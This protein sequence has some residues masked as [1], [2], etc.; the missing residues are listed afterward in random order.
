MLNR[1]KFSLQLLL[2]FSFMTGGF[3]TTKTADE[4]RV[5]FDG[6]STDAWRGYN[7]A[8]FPGDVWKVE[9]GVLRALPNLRG[10]DLITKD[11]YE[12]F[13]LTLEWKISPGGNSGIIYRIAESSAPSYTSGPEMQI[14]D[15]SANRDKPA[16]TLSGALYDLI[17]PQQK[18]LM[19]VGEFN[20]V[21]LLVRGNHVEH[22]LNGAKV[23]E[24]EL[25]SKHLQDLIAGS[26]FKDMPNF[27]RVA[28]GYIALQYHN[29]E[30]SFRN[31]KIRELP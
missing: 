19:P 31:I 3:M 16:K 2:A 6:K 25:G 13:E 7:Q 18:V 8:G 15:D 4:W 24:Y 5:L 10:G 11:Q 23:V 12:N 20:K 28:K 30:V 26:K 27:A 14:L 29:S 1:L 22:W 9:N 17:A 21:R